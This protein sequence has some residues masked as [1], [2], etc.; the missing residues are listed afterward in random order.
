MEEM[1]EVMVE[2]EGIRVDNDWV[3]AW[4][5]VTGKSWNPGLVRKARQE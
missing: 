1:K 4:D 3:A 5:D 2:S